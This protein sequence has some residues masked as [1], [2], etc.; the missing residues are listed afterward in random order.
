MKVLP[1]TSYIRTSHPTG[2]LQRSLEPR[3]PPNWVVSPV[4][5]APCGTQGPTCQSASLPALEG[6]M[7]CEPLGP[8][9]R[10]DWPRAPVLD[11]ATLSTE[12]T[13]SP[14]L[15]WTDRGS[16]RSTGRS[17][18]SSNRAGTGQVVQ[19]LGP[20]HH[21]DFPELRK[22]DVETPRQISPLA[23]PHPAGT[24]LS[25][26]PSATAASRSF[27]RWPALLCTHQQ[28]PRRIKRSL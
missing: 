26:P 16:E 25:S 9:C 3:V 22:E 27:D 12:W 17:D 8:P 20:R 23:A 19:S 28:P 7:K 6:G 13:L 2:S 4:L 15:R 11:T 1:H 18:R 24:G 10:R 21:A 14:F 5:W